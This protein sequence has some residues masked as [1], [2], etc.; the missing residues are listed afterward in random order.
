MW[1]AIWKVHI[2]PAWPLFLGHSSL[3]LS[4]KILVCSPVSLLLMGAKFWYWSFQHG[5]TAKNSSLLFRGFLRSLRTWQ[6]SKKENWPCVFPWKF[7]WFLWPLTV[8]FYPDSHP[9]T[10]KP[11]VEIVPKE[12]SDTVYHPTSLWFSFFI[13]LAA[14][15]FISL[16][17]FWYLFMSYFK[18]L[19]SFYNCS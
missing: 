18:N 10:L 1:V 13:I 5:K 9:L 4:T 19:F 12:R 17:V 2:Y 7:C 11:E 15:V 8:I 14:K 3:G 16:V 6:M